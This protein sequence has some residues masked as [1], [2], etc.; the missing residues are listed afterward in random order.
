M[1]RLICIAIAA[2]L[3]VLAAQST[4]TLGAEPAAVG[5]HALTV[6]GGSGGGTYAT[7]EKV[8]VTADA[9]AAGK[10]FDRW[11]A[12]AG[13]KLRKGDW[14]SFVLE[15]PS[16]DVRLVANYGEIASSKVIRVACVGDS[17]TE[18]TGYPTALGELLPK[19]QYEVRNFGV[20]S[21]TTLFK[22]PKP[23]YREPAFRAAKDYKPNIVVVLLGTNDTR[24]AN[25]DTYQYIA[26]FV[27][28]YKQIVSE[29][30]RVETGPR[31]YLALPTP[32]YGEGNWG[33]NEEN[34]VAGVIPGIRQVA[35]E[36]RLPVIDVHAALAD[37]PEFFKDRVQPGGEGPKALAAAVYKGIAG[38]D[39]PAVTGKK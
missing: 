25:P 3:G 22:G 16:A 1:K 24:K 21:A 31:V 5:R 6:G 19:G 2:C 10:F 38:Q 8:T 7:R 4:C 32:I 35:E 30:A 29:L 15:M 28:N 23:Y 12:P 11:E 34:L 18:I 36:L 26:D 27:A 17:I 39:P 37:R 13:L 14:S 20:S 9:P 33:L